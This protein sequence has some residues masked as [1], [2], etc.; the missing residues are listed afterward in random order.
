MIFS[1]ET[2][3]VVHPGFPRERQ[4][5]EE[6]SQPIIGNFFSRELHEIIK[7]NEI[8]WNERNWYVPRVLLGYNTEL[9]VVFTCK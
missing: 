8:I 7:L 9:Y 1:N 6:M 2:E 3:N 5:Q 4:P